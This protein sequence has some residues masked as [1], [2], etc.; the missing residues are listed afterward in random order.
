MEAHIRAVLA[1]IDKMAVRDVGR[2]CELTTACARIFASRSCGHRG[3]QYKTDT[4]QKDSTSFLHMDKFFEIGMQKT[5]SMLIQPSMK[6]EII[7]GR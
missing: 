5:L 4:T 1:R 3:S 2:G 7:A 6:G